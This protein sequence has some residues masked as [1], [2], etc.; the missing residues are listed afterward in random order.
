[1]GDSERNNPVMTEVMSSSSN[2]ITDKKLV[3][4]SNF[5]QWKKIVKLTLT[6]RNQIR[7]ITEPKPEDDANW[8]IVDACILGQMLNA[9]ENNIVDLV[10]H[11]D[12]V[13]EMWDYLNVLY[14]GQNN[15][16][17]VYELSQEFYRSERKGRPM[18]QYFAEFK[19]MYEELNAILP[20]SANIQQM[21]LQREQLAVMV[22][23]AGIGPEYETVRSQ[24]LGGEAVASLTDTF[25]RVLRVSRESPQDITPMADS[26]ALVFQSRSGSGSRSD[27]GNRGGYSGRGGRGGGRGEGPG[28]GQGQQHVSTNNSG[29]IRTCHYCGKAGH[30]Q[31]F[32]YKLHGR[33]VHQQQFAHTAS[34]TDSSP[35]SSEGKV[36]V[37]SDEEFARYTQSQISQPASSTATLVQTGNAT[38]CLSAASCPW[39]IDSGASDHMSGLSGS[40]YEEDDW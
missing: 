37:M 4:S 34:G 1:M 38:T 28:R 22:Y 3:G 32:C 18:T 8:D 20:I 33:S 14:S 21:Q 2:R 31:K 17:R 23:L 27:G 39:I 13:K 11:I 15:L 24:I 35:Q 10:T 26:S 6:S 25:A 29:A 9:M 5:H 30:I 16:S 40:G 12:T 7:H 19:R 36:V